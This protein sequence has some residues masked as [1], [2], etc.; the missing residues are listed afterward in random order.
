[1]YKKVNRNLEEVP[2]E[3]FIFL[4]SG[5]QVINLPEKALLMKIFC[6]T[7]IKKYIT[8]YKTWHF[9]KLLFYTLGPVTTGKGV[10]LLVF[11]EKRSKLS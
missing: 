9:F 11:S 7:N 6:L 5:K 3:F 10:S 1:M 8:K 2:L 4:N